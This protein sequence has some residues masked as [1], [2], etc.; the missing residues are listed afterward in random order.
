MRKTKN[1]KE[2]QGRA[3]IPSKSPELDSTGVQVLSM[4][5]A[6]RQLQEEEEQQQQQQQHPAVPFLLLLLLETVVH[7]AP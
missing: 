4:L 3:Y 6:K 5:A 1:E 7:V 2:E